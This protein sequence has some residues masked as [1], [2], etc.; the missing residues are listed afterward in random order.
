VNAGSSR[1]P[2]EEISRDYFL[3]TRA[4]A[5]ASI[6]LVYQ[7]IILLGKI[8]ETGSGRIMSTTVH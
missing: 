1:R 2:C 4:S 8:V 6:V 7:L 5:Y 3:V